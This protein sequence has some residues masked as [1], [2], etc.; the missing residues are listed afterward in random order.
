MRYNNILLASVL[1]LSLDL[2]SAAPLPAPGWFG[3]AKTT[4][5]KAM[6]G[7]TTQGVIGSASGTT[8]QTA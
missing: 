6:S 4:L 7:K 8:A 5:G 2:T 3:N 1:I